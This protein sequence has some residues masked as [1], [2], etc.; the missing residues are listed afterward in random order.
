MC[1]LEGLVIMFLEFFKGKKV[2]ITGHTGFKGSWLSFMLSEVGADVM[3]YAL[4][5]EETSLFNMLNLDSKVSSVYHDIRDHEMLQKTFESFKPDFAIHMAAQSLVG[6]SYLKPVETYEINVLGTL[7]FLDCVNHSSSV[8]SA[9]V[10]TTD[11]VYQN[12]ERSTPYIESDPLN[13]YDPYSNSKSC[14]DLI[15]QTYQNSIISN[16]NKYLSIAR[17]GNVIGGGDF[18]STRIIPDIIRSIFQNDTLLIRNPKAIRPYQHVLEPL[19]AYLWI[20][21]SS[22]SGIYN[23]GP[24]ED[25]VLTTQDLV[26]AF[27]KNWGSSLNLRFEQNKNY[28]EAQTLLLNAT[29]IKDSLKWK[30]LLN[31]K[32]A[33]Q[34]TVEWYA[35]MIKQ[36][37]LIKLTQEQI[38]RY[39]L[40]L[41]ESSRHN[42]I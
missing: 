42:V 33:I 13:G 34:W 32:E 10:V 7:N 2:L 38:D 4:K 36:G 24:K 22:Q 12:D 14:A 18:A 1:T 28:H 29:H 20:L 40:L 31:V 16:E 35:L 3:G 25:D 19:F 30:P 5:A 26:Q 21:K 11:K 27:E 6:P 41:A 37:D 9:L 23:I 15:T 8:I 39:Q 17:A